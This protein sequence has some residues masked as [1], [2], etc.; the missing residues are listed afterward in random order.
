MLSEAKLGDVTLNL[1][2]Y[3]GKD[4]Y[5]DGDVEKSLLELVRDHPEKDYSGWIE[6]RADWP[7][8]YHLSHMRSNVIEWLPIRQS[9]KVL[10]IGSGCGALSGMLSKKAGVLDCVEL[11]Q[12][13]SEINGVR[14][15]TCSNMTI[16]VGNFQ[17]IEEDLPGDYQWIILM[18]VL[19]YAGS[20]VSGTDPWL[21]FL[22]KIKK[23]LAADGHLVI[24]IENRMGLK[25]LAG[26][27]EDHIGRYFTGVEGYPEEGGIRT[28]SRNGL[29][30]LL[31]GAG[32]NE[33]N[34]YYPY[35]D[36]KIAKDIYSDAY[37]PRGEE[38]LD[39]VWNFDRERL[40]LFNE[41][42][43]ARALLREG[44]Y[45][46]FANS[47]LVI[48][49]E[50][51]EQIYIRYSNDRAPEY[52]IRTEIFR[53]RTGRML[54]RKLALEEEAVSHV[55]ELQSSYEALRDRYQGGKLT[56]CPCGMEGNRVIFPFLEGY[57]LSA[58]MDLRLRL[59]DEEGFRNLFAEYIRRIGYNEEAPAADYD[60]AFSN[61][62][63]NG[64]SWTLIDYEWT[65]GKQIP[66]GELAFRALR[67]YMY[68]DR[69]RRTAVVNALFDPLGFT[70]EEK[71][72]LIEEEES[73]QK[74][75]TGGRLSLVELWQRIGKRVRVPA[76]LESLGDS[77]RP[78]RLQVY[79][80]E[81][82]GYS[83]EDSWF[84][85]EGYNAERE[86]MLSL[87]FTPS[88]RAF[89]IDPAVESCMVAVSLENPEELPVELALSPDGC[90]IRE[91]FAAFSGKD[92]FVEVYVPENKRRGFPGGTVSLRLILGLL[93]EAMADMLTKEEN[94]RP[95]G[96]RR[97]FGKKKRNA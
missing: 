69:K 71:Q 84:P 7:S 48:T 62:I 77:L 75:V 58:L 25:Y 51:P 80:D 20:Y 79:Q 33:I 59:G 38:L 88:T 72:R 34:W 27:R 70:S 47:F 37:L 49:G 83:E 14:N 41:K 87:E 12:K 8:L 65:Y 82:D 60:M 52:R 4:L 17:E 29:Y 6:E 15:N 90:W 54:I 93:P 64:D 31:K 68:A 92:P 26:C 21:N 63:V 91:G 66:A 76:E 85:A 35:P 22:K 18:G 96:K 11:S 9:D 3:S 43:A 56:V 67:D 50:A 32:I 40:L 45:Q 36:Y 10:E 55:L 30:A 86:T 57:T 78:D 44:I 13:R 94:G 19:E 74:F 53:T 42:D 39:N 95:A 46:D 28:F 24:G 73:F 2:H 1:T 89:R 97:L 16:F 61:I 23:H 81:G 5:S